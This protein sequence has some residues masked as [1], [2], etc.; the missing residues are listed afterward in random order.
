[1][2]LIKK[3]NVIYHTIYTISN[4][5]WEKRMLNLKMI[6]WHFFTNFYS[7]ESKLEMEHFPDF[8]FKKAYK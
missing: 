3:K 7:I 6:E 5:F 2:R 4:D 8:T 1:M